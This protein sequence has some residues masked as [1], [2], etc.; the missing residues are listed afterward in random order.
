MEPERP[1]CPNCD[2]RVNDDAE[3]CHR[4]GTQ[5]RAVTTP[6][7]IDKYVRGRVRQELAGKLEA[8]DA[9]VSS[10]GDK[11]EQL[12]WDRGKRYFLISLPLIGVIIF[13]LGFIGVKTYHDAI[14]GV[15]STSI[16]AIKQIND[17]SQKVEAERNT[18]NQTSAEAD[19][20]GSHQSTCERYSD[21]G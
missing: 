21:P 2:E 16:D 14:S 8:Q 3:F 1:R 11:A 15:R 5:L 6:E 20:Q 9:I 18:I 7:E 12:I 4:C 10:I 19:A 13:I 17:A